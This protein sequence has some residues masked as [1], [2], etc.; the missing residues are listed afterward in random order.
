MSLWSQDRGPHTGPQSALTMTLGGQASAAPR[1]QTRK[2]RLCAAKDGDAEVRTRS[3]CPPSAGTRSGHRQLSPGQQAQREDWPGTESLFS[4]F[5]SSLGPGSLGRPTLPTLQ[6]PRVYPC[7]TP[8][9]LAHPSH[10]LPL[11]VRGLGH[12]EVAARGSS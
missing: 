7:G 10:L 1:L 8:G 4:K 11:S 12:R 6:L 3:W 2:W 9:G 5:T